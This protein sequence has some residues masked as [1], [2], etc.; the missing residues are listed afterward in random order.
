M[1]KKIRIAILYNEPIV[2]TEAGRKYIS[3]NGQ[4]QEGPPVLAIDLKSK[5]SKIPFGV[6]LSETTRL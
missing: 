5:A 1:R 2:G 3:E 6:D 4:L